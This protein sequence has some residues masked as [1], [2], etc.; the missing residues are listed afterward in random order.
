MG[1]RL[2]RSGRRGGPHR[3]PALL[4][5]A[6]SMQLSVPTYCRLPDHQICIG[7]VC[8]PL[9]MFLPFLL[10]ILHSYGW[11][12]WIRKEWVTFRFWKRK[13]LR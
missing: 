12:Q 8:V 5:S 13:F 4:Q 1:G 11:F 7:P 2:G 10:G 9:N 6:R 3:P